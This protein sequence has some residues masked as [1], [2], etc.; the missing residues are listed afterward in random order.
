MQIH[1]T[2][3]GHGRVWVQVSDKNRSLQSSMYYVCN[4]NSDGGDTRFS[5]TQGIFNPIFIFAMYSYT[6]EC[7]Y[8]LS[9][10]SVTVG[11]ACVPSL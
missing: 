5:L 10:S 8:V 7:L 6:Y 9:Y 1:S 11:E 3:S 2:G 4:N